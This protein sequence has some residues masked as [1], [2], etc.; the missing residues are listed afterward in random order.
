MY[1]IDFLQLRIRVEDGGSPPK[2]DIQILTIR[3]NRNLNPPIFNQLSQSIKIQETLRIGST[4]GSVSARDAD[5]K[6]PHNTI[7]Y[8]IDNNFFDV[9]ENSGRIFLK[10]SLLNLGFEN[11]EVCF[12]ICFVMHLQHNRSL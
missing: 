12:Y 1:S 6:S 8:K 3:V 9:E 4:V 7:S 2:F 5:T 11:I 10:R